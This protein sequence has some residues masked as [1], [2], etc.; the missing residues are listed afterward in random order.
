MSERDS[1]HSTMVRLDSSEVAP[2]MV[3]RPPHYARLSPEP[4][5]VIESWG[6]TFH[7]AQVLKYIARAG[8]KDPA[9]LLEDLYKARFYLNRWIRKLG[10]E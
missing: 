1:L 2:D 6:L 10:G 7:P 4:I 3:N 9:K 5:D 8:F